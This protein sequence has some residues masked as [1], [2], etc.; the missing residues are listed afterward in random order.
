MAKRFSEEQVQERYQRMLAYQQSKIAICS[1]SR[2]ELSLA[3]KVQ[4]RDMVRDSPSYRIY[5]TIDATYVARVC[6][7]LCPTHHRS[8]W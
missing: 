7:G 5:G 2:S 1:V 3:T 4:A 6:R 8:P